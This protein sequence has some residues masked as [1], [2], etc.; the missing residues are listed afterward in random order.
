LEVEA[1]TLAHRQWAVDAERRMQAEVAAQARMQAEAKS[2]LHAEIAQ[3]NERLAARMARAAGPDGLNRLDLSP[4]LRRHLMGLGI[5]CL[6]D[7]EDQPRRPLL[8][9]I[10]GTKGLRELQTVLA[11]NRRLGLDDDGRLYPLVEVA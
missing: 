8:P 1:W 2:R 5:Y 6:R 9:V 3:R 7:L 10:L 4:A 11:E